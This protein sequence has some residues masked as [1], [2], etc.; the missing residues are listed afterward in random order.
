VRAAVPP[1]EAVGGAE[2][3]EQP[4][5]ERYLAALALAIRASR[6][7]A[8][9][10]ASFRQG[11]FRYSA[12]LSGLRTDLQRATLLFGI[13]LVLWPATHAAELFGA[14]RRASA[15]RASI[16]RLHAEALPKLPVPADPLAGLEKQW[17]DTEQ[18][19]T[20]LGVTGGGTSPLDVLR[21][22][23]A[24]LPPELEVSLEELRIERNSIKARGVTQDFRTV[25][26]VKEELSKVAVFK[27]VT[28]GN[29][30][31]RQRA[32]G[33]TFDLTIDL[34]GAQP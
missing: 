16:A 1:R 4:H 7:R 24:A 27:D 2:L 21:E 31:N 30:Q 29:V 13:L 5:P 20:H 8:A 14:A 33:V 23:S 25:D 10:A 28:A 22:I 12:D 11:E 6:T 19:A 32:A 3:L 9:A 15:L 17:T 26:R 34:R 18:L